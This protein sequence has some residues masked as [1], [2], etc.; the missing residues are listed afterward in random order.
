MSV[1]AGLL[2][3][4]DPGGMADL[5]D[6]MVAMGDAFDPEY[7]EAWTEAQCAGILGMP[8]SWL[9]IARSSDEPAG[10]ALVR[11]ITDEAELLL[12]AVRKRYR[13]QGIATAL[14]Y[15]AMTG[16]L[17]GGAGTLH[18]EVRDG[19]P[20][21]ELYRSAGFVQVGV[22]RAYYHGLSGKVFDALTFKRRL[23]VN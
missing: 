19:N 17:E 8:G 20:A 11:T 22:R 2:V 15:R 18:L 1:A 3:R 14:L 13:R 12:I 16:A 4:I 7:G 6:V 5:A 10:F 21:L 23:G 9:L